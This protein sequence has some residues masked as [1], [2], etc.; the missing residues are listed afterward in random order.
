MTR[1]ELQ[2]G[3]DHQQLYQTQIDV[4]K[5]KCKAKLKIEEHADQFT[6]GIR[7]RS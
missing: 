6:K 4:R 2:C 3:C 7:T 5:A 1:T